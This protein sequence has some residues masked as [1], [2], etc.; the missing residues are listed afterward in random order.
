MLRAR[1]RF[2]A[3]PADYD[4]SRPLIGVVGEI[5][6][7]HNT[8]SNFDLIRVVEE[9]GGECWMADIGEWVWYTD[10]EQRRRL[11]EEGR[12]FS[13]D[14]RLPLPEEPH[15]AVTTSTPSTAPSPRTSSATRSPTTCARCWS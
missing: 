4:R 14:E 6:C 11:I 9:Q 5:F 12:R 7:R 1:D 2:R 10:D 3:L 15:H 13:K 8:F